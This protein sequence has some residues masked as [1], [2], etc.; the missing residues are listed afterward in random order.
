MWNDSLTKNNIE[1]ISNKIEA[2]YWDYYGSN[3]ATVDDLE[4]KGYD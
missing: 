3:Y 4:E 1:K 2:T